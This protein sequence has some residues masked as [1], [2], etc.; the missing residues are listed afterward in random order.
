MGVGLLLCL[1]VTLLTNAI[2][3]SGVKLSIRSSFAIINDYD[4]IFCCLLSYD[5][6]YMIHP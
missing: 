4:A 5:H 3:C 1:A 6:C 2:T